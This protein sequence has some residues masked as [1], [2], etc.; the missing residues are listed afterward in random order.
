MMLLTLIQRVSLFCFV[1]LSIAVLYGC[2]SIKPSSSWK[3]QDTAGTIS[4]RH[5]ASFIEHHGK[6]YLM[7]GRRLHPVEQYDP[8]SNQWQ[9]LAMTP[10]EL[11]HFQAV[12]MDDGIYVLGAF[13]GGWPNETPVERVIR[14]NP[15]KNTFSYLH[16]IP[17]SRQRGAAG[18]VAY[19]GKIYVL[20]GLT[21]GHVNG[22][23]NWFDEYD[24]KS[25]TWK[26]LPDAPR[27]RDHFQ[28]VV[29][30]HKL[31]AI[32]GRR[33]SH[34]TG[35]GFD[36]TIPEVDVFDFATQTWSTLSSDSDL[37]TLRAGNMAANHGHKIWV[38]GGESG[39]QEPAHDEVEV[40]DTRLETWQTYPSLVQGRHGSGLAILGNYM[41]TASGCGMRGGEPEL[42][43]L[44]ALL[45]PPLTGPTLQ[46]GIQIPKWHTVTLNFEGP[47]TSELAEVNPFTHYR[48]IVDF[49]HEGK[50][51]RVRGFYATD[52]NAAHTSASAGSVWQVKFSPGEEGNWSYKA[53]LQQGENIATKDNFF[54]GEEVSLAK[55]D[56]VF[57]V[58]PSL[59]KTPDFKAL[60]RLEAIKGYFRTQENHQFWLKGGANSPENFLAYVDFDGTYRV[61]AQEREG[62]A[63]S[64]K[65][66]HRYTPHLQDWQPGDPTWQI[67]KGKGMVGAVNY[68]ADMGLNS[69][70]FLT[71]N[72]NGDGKD[73]WPYVDHKTFDRFD[74]SKLAQWD[75]VFSHMQSR[76]IA[77]HI[78][79]QETE[80]ETLL[81]GG[82]TGTLRKLYFQELVARFAHHPGLIW[83]LGEENGPAHWSPVAQ[84]DQ[85][86]IDMAN[87]LK[88][89]DPYQHPLIIHT[90][91]TP[92]EKDEILSPLLGLE[93]LD[94]LSFQV[95]KR[96]D[97]YQEVLKWLG[98]SAMADKQWLI[99]MDEIGEW[100]HGA[101]ND[102]EDPTHDTLRRHALWG[103]LLA[104]SA[105]VEWYFGAHHLHNDLTS[106]DWRSRANLWRQTAIAMDFFNQHLP[107]WEMQGRPDLVSNSNITAFAKAAE[108]YVLY[109]PAFETTDIT[110]ASVPNGYEL[111]WFDP[112]RGGELIES[113][114]Q[115][116]SGT[117]ALPKVPVERFDWVA[118]ITKRP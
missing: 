73:V 77:L 6:G 44:E 85:Q 106:E 91:S 42:S 72:I 2:Q 95:N 56:G 110:L 109:V 43:T 35:Q 26:A 61:T 118:V 17:K 81:D 38:V 66:I 102:F 116:E 92:H 94:G 51:T 80:N 25:G 64:G 54:N 11:H 52:G 31:Y 57:Q 84:T 82:D 24:P 1:V 15:E 65:G 14:F 22:Y 78:V 107:F 100:M 41:F 21:N 74:V 34:E 99:T 20:G 97:V 115:I 104:G 23:T 32:A 90:H 5:E 59:A 62:E 117:S 108:K 8:K 112:L 19:Q 16:S 98:K 50:T 47:Q 53:S 69:I 45:L 68:L 63:K 101:K 76:G 79:L 36:L 10:L 40:F 39:T 83:N 49:T 55:P 60:G 29:V 12:S 70:Y 71:L 18:A 4:A 114:T 7:G 3:T 103:S 93:S 67:D 27:F 86:R 105:G 87:Y 113:D 30:D 13:T 58:V 9:K 96:E 89:A 48:L 33:T 88:Y 37:P 28:A 46:S 75:L 111:E